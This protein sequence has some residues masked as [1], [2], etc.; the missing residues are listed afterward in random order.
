MHLFHRLPDDVFHGLSTFWDRYLCN[1]IV[2]GGKVQMHHTLLLQLV[3]STQPNWIQ[4]ALQVFRY[5]AYKWLLDH[6]TDKLFAQFG[7]RL[8]SQMVLDKLTQLLMRAAQLHAMGVPV[9]VPA[10]PAPPA[11]TVGSAAEVLGHLRAVWHP[12]G[13]G[14]RDSNAGSGPSGQGDLGGQGSAGGFQ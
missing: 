2:I 4:C 6:H 8:G 10:F 14:C 9:P 3:N 1:M 7:C 13:G 5:L 11:V 12:S